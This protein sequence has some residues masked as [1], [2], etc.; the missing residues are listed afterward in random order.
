MKEPAPVIDVVVDSQ[1]LMQVLS[2][3]L[4][5]AMKYSPDNGLVEIAVQVQNKMA[6]VTVSDNGPGIPVEFRERI[7]QKFS[8]ADSSDTRQK[9][10]TGLGLAM[11]YA[12][13]NALR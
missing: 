5:N 4:S 2:N 7:F 6:R 12:G 1:R 11:H 10:G 9:S 8:Q 13:C 3:L